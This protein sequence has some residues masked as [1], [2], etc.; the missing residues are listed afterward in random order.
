MG[1]REDLKAG[2]QRTELQIRETRGVVLVWGPS[3]E[4]YAAKR[5]KILRS[6]KKENFE[7]YTSEIL[8]KLVPSSTVP[9]TD[10]E[11][12]HWRLVDVV[13]VLNFGPGPGQELATFVNEPEF[14]G[15]AIVFHPRQWDPS[16]SQSYGASVLVNFPNRVPCSA[17]EVKVCTVVK[18]CVDRA[19]AVRRQQFLKNKALLS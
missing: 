13:L 15:K 8:S 6:L 14:L 4:P 16:R 3:F 11:R 12:E 7:T 10:Q 5:K 19:K 9:V 18:L 2:L 1:L 17:Q